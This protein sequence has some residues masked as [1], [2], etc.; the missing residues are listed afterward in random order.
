M[1]HV[2]TYFSLG[3]LFLITSCK[4]NVNTGALR[5]SP[6][7]FKDSINTIGAQIIDVRTLKEFR[8]GHIENAV[9]IDY[10]SKK[11]ND[12]IKLLNVK[13][14]VY[15]YCRSGSR[16]TKSVSVFREAGFTNIYELKGGFLN[17]ED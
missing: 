12:S 10:Y 17:W 16:S 2:F 3:L 11:F 13:A 9:N 14:P 1:R 6:E 7:V 8:E 15:I 5:L 4:T